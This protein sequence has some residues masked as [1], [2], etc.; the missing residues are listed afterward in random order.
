LVE[1][2]TGAGDTFM[3]WFLAERTMGLPVHRAL[4]RANVAAALQVM[5]PG[6]ADAIPTAT[7]VDNLLEQ[8]EGC[9]T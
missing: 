3:G 7:E 9:D 6:A 8:V 5:K 2:T 4:A 1:D